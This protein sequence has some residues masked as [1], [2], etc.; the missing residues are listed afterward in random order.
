MGNIQ[1]EAD[2]IRYKGQYRTVQEALDNAG[3]GPE[4]PTAYSVEGLVCTGCEIVTGGYFKIG[5]I[6]FVNIRFRA[7]E[8]DAISI[9]GFPA[10]DRV[11]TEDVALCNICEQI[12][13]DPFKNGKIT[14]LGVLGVSGQYAWE[15]IATAVYLCNS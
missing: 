1:M 2:Q 5:N 6:V 12:N 13:G 7:T 11:T 3:S 14:K 9:S 10:Y 8:Y 15:Y 4:L